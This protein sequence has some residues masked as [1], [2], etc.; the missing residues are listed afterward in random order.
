MFLWFFGGGYVAVCVPC[1]VSGE[2]HENVVVHELGDYMYKGIS[3]PVKVFEILP[4]ELSGRHPF[5]EIRKK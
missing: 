4:V 3:E 2:F 5:P 1:F